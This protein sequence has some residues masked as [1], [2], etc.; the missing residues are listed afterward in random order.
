VNKY[1]SIPLIMRKSASRKLTI[2]FCWGLWFY[3]DKI[4]EENNI[5]L[6]ANLEKNFKGD[7]IYLSTKA[8]SSKASNQLYIWL[9]FYQVLSSKTFDQLYRRLIGLIRLIYNFLYEGW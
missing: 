4:Y 2:W 3:A 9:S 1:D 5:A 6:T 7:K 8:P